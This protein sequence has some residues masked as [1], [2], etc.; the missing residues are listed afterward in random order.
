[1][2]FTVKIADVNIGISSLFDEVYELCRDYLSQEA[3]EL[4][5][6]TEMADITFEREKAR[7][8]AE[9]E[10]IPVYNFSDSYLET[11]S[12]YRKI[13]TA[14]LRYDAF[15]MH[16]AVI[17]LNG[18]AY[19]FTAPSGVGKTTHTG[20]WLKAFPEA[21]M[22]NGDKPILRMENGG[23][24]AYGTPWAGKEGLNKNTSLPLKAI[25]ILTRG[26]QNEITP[27][28]FGNVYPF[29]IG[30]TYRPTDAQEMSKTLELIKKLGESTSLYLLK[31]NLDPSAATVAYNGMNTE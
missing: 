12:V 11:L 21:F 3:P 26:E 13:A 10:H 22:L 9:Y 6:K 29:L 2:E 24:T 7:R 8:E 1:M 25:C 30:Q 31:C 23:F 15:L 16:G 20:F 28:K 19:M 27:V 18:Q 14:L 17:G 5:V 4:T